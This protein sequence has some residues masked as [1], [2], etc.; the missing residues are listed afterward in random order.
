[1]Y[2]IL[3]GKFVSSEIRKDLKDEVNKLKK[4]NIL[5][6]LAV[7]ICGDDPASKI[8]VKNKSKACNDLDI[9]YEEYN[10]DKNISEFELSE[11]IRKLNSRKDINGILVQSP[12]PKTIDEN[13][14]FSLIDEKKDVD[15]FNTLNVGKLFQGQN[16]FIPCTPLGIIKLLEFYNINIEGLSTVIIGRSNIIGKPMIECLLRKNAT[17]TVCHSKTKNIRDITKNADIIISCVGKENMVTE[18]MV[19]DN[20]IIIDVGMNK[21][22]NGHLIGDVDFKNVINKAS[23][24]TPV[25]GGVGPM[26][27]TM[28]MYNVIK[29]CKLQNG[30]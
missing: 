28:L 10:L 8:Y 24:I 16:T 19:K 12:L 2:K 20:A 15:G 18:D 9:K 6:T 17:V 22:V 23:Y 11:I 21:D 25:P 3:D 5:V 27:I 30:I 1:M 26:T 29:A 4:N 13:K 7:I 14:I